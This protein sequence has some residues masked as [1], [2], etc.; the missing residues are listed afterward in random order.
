MVTRLFE[1]LF[2][3]AAYPND[4]LNAPELVFETAMMV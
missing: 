3:Q 1:I 2:L 4:W